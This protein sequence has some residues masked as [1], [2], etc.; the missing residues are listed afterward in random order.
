[1]AK[2]LDSMGDSPTSLK[3]LFVQVFFFD[4]DRFCCADPEWPTKAW[5]SCLRA[6]SD[7]SKH[8]CSKR[9]ASHALRSEVLFA[10]TL[11]EPWSSSL[12]VELVV[13]ARVSE[14]AGS[15]CIAEPTEIFCGTPSALDIWGLVSTAQGL[16]HQ[17]VHRSSRSKKGQ[18]L[19]ELVVG[20]YD[21]ACCDVVW[22]ACK[23]LHK[24]FCTR[25]GNLPIF[26]SRM[27][28]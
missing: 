8:S 12:A 6:G 5:T 18:C 23:V 13:G 2:W 25:D 3:H 16:Q 24:S 7:L 21:F 27:P 28:T 22:E 26:V 11:E 4:N 17:E 10:G 9:K 20:K 15:Q 1:M 19:S 14:E